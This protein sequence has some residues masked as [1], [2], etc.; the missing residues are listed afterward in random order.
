[1]I[2]ADMGH[3]IEVGVVARLIARLQNR[4][5]IDCFYQR[6]VVQHLALVARHSE[7]FDAA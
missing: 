6:Q 4:E 1:M 7:D 3:P 2:V 5:A